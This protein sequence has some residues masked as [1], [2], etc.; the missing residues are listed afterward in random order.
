MNS[1]DF[2]HLVKYLQIGREIALACLSLL[3]SCTW[4]IS[5][6]LALL[7]TVRRSKTHTQGRIIQW[8]LWAGKKIILNFVFTL[9]ANNTLVGK[10]YLQ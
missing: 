9:S 2:S 5:L 1:Y 7:D 4:I 10:R 3:L 8:A 6:C